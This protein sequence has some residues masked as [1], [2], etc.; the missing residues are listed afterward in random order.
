MSR[1]L[2]GW[3]SDCTYICNRQY[4]TQTLLTSGWEKSVKQEVGL[5]REPRVFASCG[6]LPRLFWVRYFV[7][8]GER[9]ETCWALAAVPLATAG[10]YRSK[11]LSFHGT[12]WAWGILGSSDSRNKTVSSAFQQA[13]YLQQDPAPS[14]RS[15]L[16]SCPPVQ[17]LRTSCA[18]SRR[19]SKTLPRS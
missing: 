9:P 15:T 11:F 5:I 2:A 19:R 10:R 17:N 3:I 4:G 6:S 14:R 8:Q 12:N 1:R 16:P 18:P 7:F 13:Y